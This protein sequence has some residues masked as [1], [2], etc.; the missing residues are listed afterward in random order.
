MPPPQAR[1]LAV[2]FG[3]DDGPAVEPFLVGVATLSL[4][5][6]AAEESLVL[7][8]VDDAH[9]LDAASAAALL[10]CAR[11]LGADRVA[12]A[13]GARDGAGVTF[14]A[15]GLTELTLTGLDIEQSRELL[16]QRLGQ[17][18][19]GRGRPATRRVRHVATRWRSS[20]CRE[21]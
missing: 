18:A 17:R 10:F 21:S 4:L 3:E 9:W 19:G 16:A 6:T 5:T 11:R 15:P 12:M 2:A 13:F 8:V 14:E 1:A 7:C 20:S